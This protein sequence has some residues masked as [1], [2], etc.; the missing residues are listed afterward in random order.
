MTEKCQRHVGIEKLPK[1]QLAIDVSFFL[2]LFSWNRYTRHSIE[3]FHLVQL[4]DFVHL[5]TV[6]YNSGTVLFIPAS[7]VCL[8][9]C[10]RSSGVDPPFETWAID[11]EASVAARYGG[12]G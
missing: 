5:K 1:I 6:K 2:L 11:S 4:Q 3:G 9:I 10:Y 12:L 8:F 7:H